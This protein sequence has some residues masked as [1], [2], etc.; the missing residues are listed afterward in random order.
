MNPST[1]ENPGIT[2]EQL[3][4]VVNSPANVKA[5]EAAY[6]QPAL[7][8]FEAAESL[9]AQLYERYCAAVGGVAF[10]G[11]PLPAWATFKA[12]PSKQKQVGAWIQVGEY[13]R[14]WALASR[15]LSTITPPAGE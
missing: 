5:I 7:A 6:A 15:P 10:N 14:E 4:A 9:A 3:S 8:E 11:D 2:E 12:D 13:A 1:P